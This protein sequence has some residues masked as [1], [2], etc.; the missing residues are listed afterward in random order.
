MPRHY[1]SV[2]EKKGLLGSHS[3][4]LLL[5]L[6]WVLG[7][8]MLPYYQIGLKFDLNNDMIPEEVDFSKRSKQKFASTAG[9]NFEK[10]PIEILD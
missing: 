6:I 1:L 3:S 2:Q 5:L 8:K 10:N 7:K 4:N 9:L